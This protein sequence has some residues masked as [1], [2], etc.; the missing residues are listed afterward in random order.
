MQ[1]VE[2]LT[3]EHLIKSLASGRPYHPNLPSFMIVMEGRLV[4]KEEIQINELCE[5]DA[6]LVQPQRIYQVLEISEGSKIRILKFNPEN[7]DQLSLKIR[8]IRVYKNR[9]LPNFNHFQMQEEE[10][11]RLWDSMELIRKLSDEAEETHYQ[12]EIIKGYLSAILYQILEFITHK[13]K[14]LKEKITRQQELVLWYFDLIEEHYIDQRNVRFYAEKMSISERY[15]N[16]LININTGKSP[17]SL[18]NEYVLNKSKVLLSSSTLSIS[19]IAYQLR[20]SD[21]YSFSHFFKRHLSVS[22]K[23]YRMRFR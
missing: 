11:K 6:I 3:E 18:I 8:K 2:I 9:F 7:I 23:V 10:T 21:L 19:E 14:L 20:F 5:N 16:K 13:N 12:T 4:I 15:L 1:E 22:P 17:L